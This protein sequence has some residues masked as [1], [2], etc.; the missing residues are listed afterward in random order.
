[1]TKNRFWIGVV[2]KAHVLKGIEGGFA[3]LNHGKKTPLAKMKA[4]D[5]IIYYS[6]RL[7]LESREPYQHFTAVGRVKTGEVYQYDMGNGFVPYRLKVD[8]ASAREVPIL[9]L[10]DKLSFTAGKKSWGQQFRFGHFEISESDFV[11]LANEMGA[12]IGLDTLK[13]KS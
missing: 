9:P 4:G 3:Q 13:Q 6:P 2:S 12:E 11:L 8:F 5:W 10:L 7:S 1:M